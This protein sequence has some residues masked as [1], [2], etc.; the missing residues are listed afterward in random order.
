MSDAKIPHQMIKDY[1]TGNQIPDIGAEGHRQAVERFLVED[2]GYRREDIEVD[3]PISFE[4]AGEPY[5]S[6]VDLVVSPNGGQT[7]LI[8]VKCAAASLGSRE[9]EILAAARLLDSYQIPLCLVSD[10][11]R[12]ILLDTLTGR[13]VGDSWDAVPSRQQALEMLDQLDLKPLPESWR[14]KTRLIFRSYDS[15]NVNV[16]RKL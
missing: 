15:L 2:K 12:A 9:R 13:Q 8:A 14:E 4:V 7:R 5:H 16:A 3:V 6:A 1:I 10:G 11:R